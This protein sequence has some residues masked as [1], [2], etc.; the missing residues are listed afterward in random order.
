MWA[1]PF[2]KVAVASGSGGSNELLPQ[3]AGS[4]DRNFPW[5]RHKMSMSEPFDRRSALKGTSLSFRAQDLR[6]AAQVLKKWP[7][8]EGG[9]VVVGRGP[10]RSATRKYGF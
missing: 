3:C 4:N 5:K 10:G 2:G 7:Q 8:V 6:T 9:Y 1:A